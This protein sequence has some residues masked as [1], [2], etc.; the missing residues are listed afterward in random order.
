M[1]RS[2]RFLS[3]R[4]VVVVVECDFSRNRLPI[5]CD[6]SLRYLCVP[7]RETTSITRKFG[8]TLCAYLVRI[9]TM[10]IILRRRR[11][12][13]TRVDTRICSARQPNDWI[14]FF[15]ASP[16]WIAKQN[17]CWLRAFL[18]LV[19]L[20]SAKKDSGDGTRELLTNKYQK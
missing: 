15:D 14:F 13:P 8:E 11:T 1:C 18:F 5:A 20:S 7:L 6:N 17:I 12:P 9:Y 2:G 3:I 16:N 19:F 10:S 4:F